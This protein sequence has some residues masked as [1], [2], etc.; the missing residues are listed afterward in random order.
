MRRGT[1]SPETI[2]RR[3]PAFLARPSALMIIERPVESMKLTRVRSRISRSGSRCST[4]MS[5]LSTLDA[6]DM[7]S[8]PVSC[9]CMPSLRSAVSQPTL[10]EPDL[11]GG[12]A[13]GAVRPRGRTAFAVEAQRDPVLGRLG[14][15]GGVAV[16]S[17]RLP[18]RLVELELPA[19]APAARDRAGIATRLALRD[20]LEHGRQFHARA[21]A[22][23]ARAAVARIARA[24][25]R[26]ATRGVA[27]AAGADAELA[28]RGR[29]GDP[30]GLQT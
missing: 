17:V 9:T 10:I 11:N 18:G 29:A 27:G 25:R 23:L 3:R 19:V 14:R 30:V 24:R 21:A 13:S 20:P 22:G 5:R 26:R 16:A 12:G 28:Q 1:P 7:S 6:L 4:S 8:S 2:V 15:R